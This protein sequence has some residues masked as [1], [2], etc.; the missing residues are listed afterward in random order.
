[1]LLIGDMDK[2]ILYAILHVVLQVSILLFYR[3]YG[4]HHFEEAR[5]RL[6]IDRRIFREILGFS[7]W[8]MFANTAIALNNQ[9]I[10]IL[11]NMFFAP[12][13]VAARS[14]SIQVNMAAHQ[15]VS[16]FQTAAVPQIVKR[17]AA[18]DFDGS[19]HLLLDTAKYSFYLMM[20]LCV[21]IC[22][23]AEQLLTLWLGVVPPYTTIFLQLIVVQGL[24]QVFDTTFYY[25]LYAKGQ[26][27]ENALISPTL[28][29]LSFPVV[30]ILFKMGYSPVALS[31]VFLCNYAILGFVVKPILVTRIAHYTWHDIFSVF[32]P[33]L[34][35]TLASLPIPFIANYYIT[36]Q[37]FPMWL[38]FILIV[39]I[40]VLSVAAS[41]WYLG[42]TPE[43]RSKVLDMIRKKIL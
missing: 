42:L 36:S 5:F 35:V 40:C 17:Y 20:M 9:G 8:S 11:L 7:G 23:T 26:L 14:I 25:S 41:S 3:W 12:A 28:G 30:Y 43:M 13:V 4:M 37:H 6:Y 19:K 31:W 22:F 39:A 33:C 21:P 1:M 24:C 32:T 10:L 27:R 29:F 18:Q 2:L 34:K 38:E 16:N 15:F